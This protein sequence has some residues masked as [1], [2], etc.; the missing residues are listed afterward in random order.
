LVAASGCHQGDSARS[1]LKELSA[2]QFHAT[3]S[4]A[5]TNSA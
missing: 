3:F 2:R 1:D 5:G 4:A